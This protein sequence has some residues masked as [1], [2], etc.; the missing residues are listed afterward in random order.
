[1]LGSS[2]LGAGAA[3]N[4]ISNERKPDNPNQHFVAF[5]K[6]LTARKDGH[7]QEVGMIAITQE[8]LLRTIAEQE[9]EIEKLTAR[10]ERARNLSVNYGCPPDKRGVDGICFSQIKECVRCRDKYIM[11]TEGV[12]KRIEND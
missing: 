7:Y 3:S 8:D 4:H 11:G 10:L 6:H 12:R 9:A 1:M 5:T 2:T